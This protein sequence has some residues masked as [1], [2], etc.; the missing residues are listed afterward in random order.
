MLLALRNTHKHFRDFGELTKL[1]F[2]KISITKY[3][4]VDRFADI[5]SDSKSIG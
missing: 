1:A 2:N 3:S 4:S 5:F